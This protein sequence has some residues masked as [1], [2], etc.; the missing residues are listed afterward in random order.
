[1]LRD[2][3]SEVTDFLIFY[4]TRHLHSSPRCRVGAASPQ[5]EV[6]H[7]QSLHDDND[8]DDDNEEGS[9]DD[10]DNDGSGR[11]DDNNDD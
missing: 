5:S 6:A 11:L 8:D 9:D 2:G 7:S 4:R 10:D 1:M 3:S